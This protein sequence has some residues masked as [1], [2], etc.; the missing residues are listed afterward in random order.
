MGSSRVPIG[1]KSYRPEVEILS[2]L[3][4]A[5]SQT[6]GRSTPIIMNTVKFPLNRRSVHYVHVTPPHFFE[7]SSDVCDVRARRPLSGVCLSTGLTLA[8]LESENN[9]YSSSFS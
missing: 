9:R 4:P 7:F 1:I 3:F 2:L 8:C 5:A 6:Y